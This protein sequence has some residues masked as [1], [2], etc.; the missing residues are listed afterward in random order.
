MSLIHNIVP[1]RALD[2]SRLN[3]FVSK[4]G[5]TAFEDRGGGTYYYWIK[6]KS[7]RGL[8][9]T[10][11][12]NLIEV[13]NTV[14]SNRYDY[15]LTNK[16]VEQILK[17]TDG[18]ILDEENEQVEALPLF[19]NDKITEIELQDCEIIKTLSQEHD[20]IAIYGPTRTVHFG[21]RLYAQFNS[22]S[23]K[24][25]RDKMFDI[26]LNVNYKLPNF[27]Y[28]SIMEVGNTEEEKKIMIVLT[29]KTDS[30]LDKYDYIIFNTNNDRLIMITNEILNSILPSNWALVD[31]FTI[32]APIID[33]V[34]W[35]NLIE[36]AK[37]FDL[38]DQYINKNK[39]ANI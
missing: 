19:N 24:Q 33:E 27:E 18:I 1:K 21:K 10:I 29:N 28:G 9:L 14:L 15:E 36:N 4:I 39:N 17:L 26:I 31:E 11:E 8:D 5:N 35:E 12:E 20:G 25:L 34:Q 13:R 38:Y 6:G 2:I 23:G 3:S 32:V 37:K 30:I 16:I 7:T 22:Y